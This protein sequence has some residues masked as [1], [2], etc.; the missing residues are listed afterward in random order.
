MPAHID[1]IHAA[2]GKVY[3]V[4]GVVR[5]RLLGLPSKDADLLVTG[6][7]AAALKSLLERLGEVHLVGQ[8]FGVLK[9]KPKGHSGEPIDIALPR[10]ERSTGAGHRDFEVSF[11]HTLP[12]DVDLGR[13][14]FT[15]NAIAQD[16]RTGEF[17]DPHGGRKDLEARKLRVVFERAFEEDPLRIL[18]GIQF[19]ARLKL[20]VEPATRELMK[21]HAPLVATVSVERVVQELKKLLLAQTPSI[22]FYLMREVGVMKLILPELEA[23]TG[24]LQPG[25]EKVGDAFDHTLKVLDAARGDAALDNAGDATLMIAALF[26]DLGKATTAKLEENGRL[27]FHGH[28]FV[29]KKLAR[30]RMEQLKIQQMGV[31]PDEILTLVENHMFDTGP[32][33]TD[34]ALRRFA[35][36]IGV[37]LVFKQIDLRI[38][39]NRG[40][41]HPQNIKKPLNLRRRIREELDRKAPFGLK[42]LAINGNDLL[43]HG[44]APGP[45]IGLKLNELLE[46][47]LDEPDLNTREELL[48]RI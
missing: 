1:A 30:R 11:D 18:R 2:G 47:V 24:V 23:L 10:V 22:G 46:L 31:S 25:K 14:D 41:A 19:A 7:P 8:S 44:Y 5:D 40:G 39:D 45:K 38:A 35:R 16:L 32:E 6:V 13:R 43:E 33:F 27:T 17:V 4:G 29:S 3:E 36:K 15:V 28:Q 9:F 26:H 34:K 12:V 37:P 20:V 48:K 21:K 42:D